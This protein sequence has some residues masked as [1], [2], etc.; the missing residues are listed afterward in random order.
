M[1]F[2]LSCLSYFTQ[3]FSKDH[4][5]FEGF[6]NLTLSAFNSSS[7]YETFT[8]IPME[9]KWEKQKKTRKNLKY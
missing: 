8:G 2:R 6:K 9:F 4:E 1:F 7:D 3:L 5:D